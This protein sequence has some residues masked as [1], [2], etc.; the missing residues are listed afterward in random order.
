MNVKT[1]WTDDAQNVLDGRVTVR[2]LGYE[3]PS[4]VLWRNL[5]FEMAA[6][7]LLALRGQSGTGKT[8][9]LQCI[10]SLEQPTAGT[11]SVAGVSVNDLRGRDQRRFLRNAVG[12]VFQNSGLVASWTVRKNLEV[13]GVAAS[14]SSRGKPL[15]PEALEIFEH[16]G[17][18][19]DLAN[20]PVFRLSGGEQQRVAMM[21]LALQRPA[22]LLL[23]EPTS[24][25]D[26]VNTARLLSFVDTHRRNGGSAIIA[27]HDARVIAHAD[28]D[29]VLL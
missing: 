12:F 23:D 24:A 11:I 2:G 9:L 19:P 20:T 25:L 22:V 5:S 7:G 26:D 29:V 15:T 3:F 10:G 21:R 27:T 17:L 28:C 13:S 6:G 16:F 8:T 1:H 4:R 14:E 18:P